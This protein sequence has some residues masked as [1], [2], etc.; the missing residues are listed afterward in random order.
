[1]LLMVKWF[2]QK[3]I[4]ICIVYQLILY[5]LSI[6]IYIALYRYFIIK[7]LGLNP[8]RTIFPLS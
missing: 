2:G 8:T 7:R 5:T 1:M 4:L 3:P 6:K